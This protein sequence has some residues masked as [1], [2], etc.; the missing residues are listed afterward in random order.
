MFESLYHNG[1]EVATHSDIND[2]NQTVK[3]VSTASGNSRSNAPKTGDTANVLTF[4]VV[5][6]IALA[7]GVLVIYKKRKMNNNI[8]ETKNKK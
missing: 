7:A 3:I 4:I 6:I 5:M 8:L 2:K 1:V